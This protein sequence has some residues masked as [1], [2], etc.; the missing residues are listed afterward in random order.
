M[1]FL[2]DRDLF[3]IDLFLA[4]A[5]TGKVQRQITKTAVDAHYQSLEFIESAGSWSPDGKRFVFAGISGGHPV[6]VL[7]DVDRKK[8]EREIRFPELGEILNPS[9]SPDGHAIAFSGLVGGLTD[10]YVYDLQANDLRRL[11]NDQYADLQPAWSPD[12]RTLAFA[13]DRFTSQLER[14]R[15]RPDYASR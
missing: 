5:R 14:P 3:S 6:L 10:L 2:S 12:G 7:Y 8:R 4:D 9:W 13:T 15:A 1:M 11:T